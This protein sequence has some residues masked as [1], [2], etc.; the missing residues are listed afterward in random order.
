MIRLAV[1]S[2]TFATLAAAAHA[3]QQTYDFFGYV[4][5]TKGTFGCS[6]WPDR[7]RPWVR[8]FFGNGFTAADCLALQTES[9]ALVGA[10]FCNPP[11][12]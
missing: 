11:L 12:H 1:L 6:Q 10:G 9:I 8:I 5:C 4:P 7:G 2:L 3:Q